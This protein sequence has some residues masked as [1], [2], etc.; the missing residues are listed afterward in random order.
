MQCQ[1]LQELKEYGKLDASP[2]DSKL[3]KGPVEVEHWWH[4]PVIP[5]LERLGRH[6]LK[7]LIPLKKNKKAAVFMTHE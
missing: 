1:P 7:T 6:S 5:V 4:A 2:G 3:R